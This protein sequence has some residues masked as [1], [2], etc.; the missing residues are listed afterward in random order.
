MNKIIKDIN[1]IQ[2]ARYCNGKKAIRIVEKPTSKKAYVQFA[3]GMQTWKY[4]NEKCYWELL[5]TVVCNNC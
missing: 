3:D 5:S 1:T 2:C 4:N